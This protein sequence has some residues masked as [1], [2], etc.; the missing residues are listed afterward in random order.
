MLYDTPLIS[1]Y[2]FVGWMSMVYFNKPNLVPAFFSSIILIIIFDRNY[3]A[4]SSD[5]SLP[6]AY[7]ALSM[8]DIISM[9]CLGHRTVIT[10]DSVPN[11][12]CADLHTYQKLMEESRHD[13]SDHQEFPFSRRRQYK[14]ANIGQMLVPR[15]QK[16]QKGMYHILKAVWIFNS[17]F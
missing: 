8:T 16:N 9:L 11:L 1:V 2:V 4:F 5:Q 6:K 3:V 15:S 10:N 14:R 12:S 17:S 13:E 7:K